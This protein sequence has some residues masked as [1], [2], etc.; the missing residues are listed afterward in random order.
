[1]NALNLTI[2][3]PL[4][5]IVT[6]MSMLVP[7]VQLACP[8]NKFRIDYVLNLANQK[9]F[10]FTAVSRSIFCHP[11]TPKSVYHPSIMFRLFQMDRRF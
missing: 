1:M 8:A 9:D 6:A 11:I 7:P 5:T 10:E 4:Q 3:V 2:F